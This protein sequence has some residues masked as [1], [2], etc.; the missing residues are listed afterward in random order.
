MY[1]SI[2]S[3]F[4]EKKIVGLNWHKHRYIDHLIAIEKYILNNPKT[5]TGNIHFHALKS[6]Y[7]KEFAEILRELKPSDHQ[8]YQNELSLLEKKQRAREKLDFKKDIQLKVEWQ[9]AKGL[10]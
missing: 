6:K 1:L 7:S 5:F 10:I 9:K 2:K 3:K 8:I 4:I